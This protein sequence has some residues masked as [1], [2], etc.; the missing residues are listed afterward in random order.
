MDQYTCIKYGL[1]F[2]KEKKY[3]EA[4]E[5]F[6][7]SNRLNPDCSVT[8][9]FLTETLLV[10]GRYREGLEQN[11][12]RFQFLSDKNILPEIEINPLVF[13]IYPKLRQCYKKPLWTGQDL[14]GKRILV[15]NEAGFGD[16]INFCRY[17]PELKKL[18]VYIILE[19]KSELKK[20]LEG[21]ADEIIETNMK[22]RVAE[23][24]KTFTNLKTTGLTL[25]E[26]DYVVS[27]N[28]FTYLF[29]KELDNIPLKV[30]YIQ[31]KWEG[32]KF[33]D[34]SKK[35]KIGIIWA[36]NEKNNNDANRSCYLR[37]FNSISKLEDFQLFSLQIGN[38]KRKWWDEDSQKN[39]DV[40]LLE[41]SEVE[42]IDL[43]L[44]I[45]DF[46]ETALA[47]NELDLVITVD[48]A[49]AHLAGA[50]GR[51]VWILLPYHHEWRWQKQWYP[52]MSKVIQ[53]KQGDWQ[54]VFLEVEEK[55]HEYF[56][57]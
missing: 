32:E 34:T 36:G 49:I 56:D 9:H 44:K 53:P 14:T 40:N 18:G 50:L 7:E 12:R 25:P 54:T 42:Y 1:A 26:H 27:L 15:F 21:L 10:M 39:Y 11:D 13:E 47:I 37:H 43:A 31:A 29:D 52:T 41:G 6:L 8:R 28:S 55:L 5:F 22:Q 38:M 23:F 35:W 16:A 3:K 20:L 33:T 57:K 48:T 45:K 17:L 19:V 46:N 24:V 4:C 51:Q 30:P 2:Y